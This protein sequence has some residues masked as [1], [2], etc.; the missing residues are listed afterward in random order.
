MAASLTAVVLRW[1]PIASVGRSRHNNFR[2]A[3]NNL[4]G[5]GYFRRW[6][7]KKKARMTV[8]RRLLTMASE[9]RRTKKMMTIAACSLCPSV[10]LLI[11]RRRSDRRKE[12]W[13]R[14]S[15]KRAAPNMELLI[16]R[17]NKGFST[18]YLLVSSI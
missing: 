6:P 10:R 2:S 11:R 15:V 12:Q 16:T 7:N 5:P 9:G 18:F 4:L 3:D 1:L 13:I 8:W 17:A 14:D